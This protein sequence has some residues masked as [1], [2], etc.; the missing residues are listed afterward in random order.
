MRKIISLVLIVFGSFAVQAQSVDGVL[1]SEI[2]VTYI[3]LTGRGRLFNSKIRVQVD[4]GQ[5]RSGSSVNEYQITDSNGKLM[6]FNSMVDA[7]N[8]FD[9]LGYEY[10]DSEYTAEDRPIQ[11]LLRKKKPEMDLANSPKPVTGEN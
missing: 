4:F 5:D 2:D 6:E 3:E 11:Y 9:H 7:L 1:L 8:F 10:I